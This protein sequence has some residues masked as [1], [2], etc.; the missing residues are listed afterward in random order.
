VLR[1]AQSLSRRISARRAARVDRYGAA[2]A[3]LAATVAITMLGP[4]GKVG[5]SVAIVLEAATLLFCV[6]ASDVS[7]RSIAAA[8]GFAAAA[9]IVGLIVLATDD[10]QLAQTGTAIVGAALAVIVPVP[11]L[12][13]IARHPR[14]TVHTIAGALCLYLLAGIL[15][16]NVLAVLD[17]VAGP[18]FVQRP[19]ST[20]ADTLYFSFVTL[21]TLGYGDLTPATP[22]ARLIAVTETIGGQLYLVTILALLVSNLGG[23]RSKDGGADVPD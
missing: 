17:A 9:A 14:I 15:A 22:L 5:A 4:L 2:L 11:I 21:A 23:V 13:R 1:A 12:R 10:R 18:V 7:P 3:L 8:R 20:I 6:D 16:A 19:V